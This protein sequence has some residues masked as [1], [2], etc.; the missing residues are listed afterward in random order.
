MR[1][2]IALLL[3]T[4]TLSW[5]S[6]AC[7]QTPKTP[8]DEP[9]APVALNPQKTVLLD[10]DDHKLILETEVVLRAGL[11]EML[12]C[13]KQTKEHESILSLDAKAATVHA[14]LL[15]LGSQPGTPVKFDPEFQPPQGQVIEIWMM[16]K[17]AEGK[18][19]RTKAQNW[20]RSVTRKYHI[21]KL[22]QFPAGVKIPEDSDLRYDD[23]FHELLWFGMMSDRD[24]DRM[25]ALSADAKYQAA[26]KEL[27]KIS[28][29]VPMTADWVFSGSGFYRDEATGQQHYL[30]EGGDL[31]CVANFSTATL[32]VREKSSANSEGGLSYE[33]WEERIPPLGTKVRVELIPVKPEPEEKQPPADAPAK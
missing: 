17:D 6:H 14:G 28:Q 16:W 26:V 9:K 23:K 22:E 31:I 8:A 11:L 15:A 27:H 20:I 33:A 18:W 3:S 10:R 13:L 1:L 32:D 4:V 25:L 24:R 2:T 30:A 29:V 12:V 7:A 5:V 21:A 19:Q